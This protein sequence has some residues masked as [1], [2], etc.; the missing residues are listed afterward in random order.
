MLTF[1]MPFTTPLTFE[2]SAVDPTFVFAFMDTFV[3]ILEDYFGEISAM[4]LKDHFD[5]V[6]QVRVVCPCLLSKR[7]IYILCLVSF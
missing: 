2:W 4:T 5:T 7:D 3:E 1:T 6:Y